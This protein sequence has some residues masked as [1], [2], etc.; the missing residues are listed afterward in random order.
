MDTPT[1][2]VRNDPLP[3]PTATRKKITFFT[4]A[5]IPTTNFV[6]TTGP[7]QNASVDESSELEPV[8]IEFSVIEPEDNANSDG[9]EKFAWTT[10]YNLKPN[11]RYEVVF[12][13]IEENPVS[14]LNLGFGIYAPVGT[15]EVAVPL[16][17]IDNDPGNPL[18]PGRYRWGVMLVKMDPEY[19]R[20]QYLGG[21]RQFEY[22]RASTPECTP[23]YFWGGKSCD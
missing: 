7:V 13:D 4:A 18:E 23:Q 20:L 14:D 9:E 3:A 19:E 15:T 2:T 6:P 21:D 11:E 12:F 22:K 16:D 8:A 10:N 5:P 17:E 1:S